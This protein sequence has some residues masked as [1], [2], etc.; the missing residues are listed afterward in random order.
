MIELYNNL[1]PT[2]S[3]PGILYG[4]PKVLKPSIPLRP[5]V[6]TIN[7]R[8]SFHSLSIWCLYF[9][10]FPPTSIPYMTRFRLLRIYFNKHLIMTSFDVTS[11][12]TNIALD[13][14]I[15]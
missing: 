12:F 4:L 14:T 10:L 7:S 11:L 6:S 9:V 8:A 13:E 1:A 2:G 15:Y 3:R 5:I